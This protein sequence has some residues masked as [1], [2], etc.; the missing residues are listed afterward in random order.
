MHNRLLRTEI[1]NPLQRALRLLENHVSSDRNY[2]ICVRNLAGANGRRFIIR[3][4]LQTS[5]HCPSWCC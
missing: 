2:Q 3:S 1:L 4:T 5:R